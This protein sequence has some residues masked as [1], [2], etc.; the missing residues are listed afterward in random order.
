MNR[1][2]A[3][4]V[5]LL[6]IITWLITQLQ[7][8]PSSQNTTGQDSTAQS[9]SPNQNAGQP[10]SPQIPPALATALSQGAHPTWKPS[11]PVTGAPLRFGR[12]QPLGLK[13]RILPVRSLSPSTGYLTESTVAFPVHDGS[14]VIG[15][16]HNITPLPSG[17]LIEGSLPENGSFSVTLRTD[18]AS[19]HLLFPKAFRAIEVRTEPNGSILMI[20]R[21]LS[22][23]LCAPGLPST[24]RHAA[25]APDPSDPQRIP[26]EATAPLSVPLLE[27]L[28][29]VAA[30]PTTRAVI[31]P[32][33]YLH[34]VNSKST[35]V[36]D[37]GYWN[38]GRPFPVANTTLSANDIRYI[39]D[40]VAEDFRPFKVNVTTNPAIR[41]LAIANKKNWV[42]VW[43][44][45]TKTAE[46]TAGGIAVIDGFSTPDRS[47]SS[48]DPTKIG[49][50]HCWAFTQTKENCADTISHEA[51]HTFGLGHWG[52]PS[53]EYYDGH[54]TSSLSWKPIMGAGDKLVSH[55]TKAGSY[56]QQ[57]GKKSSSQDDTAIIQ[58]TNNS[59]P[60]IP[61]EDNNS[62]SSARPLGSASPIITAK[63]VIT[64]KADVDFFSFT[65]TGGTVDVRCSPAPISPNL[66][67]RLSLL[68][69]K[70]ELLESS[71]PID[72]M[73]AAINCPVPRGTYYVKVEGASHLLPD[74]IPANFFN[75]TAGIALRNNGFTKHGSLGAYS[76]SGTISGKANT[77][78]ITSPP[79]LSGTVYAAFS[80]TITAI[81]T[82]PL[83]EISG[84]LPAGLSFDP[85]TAT[86]SGVPTDPNTQTAAVL[87]VP[88]QR[89]FTIKGLKLSK[90]TQV[91]GD[92]IPQ[93]T[94]IESISGSTITL[95]KPCTDYSLKT[96]TVEG[97]T[98]TGSDVVEL[99]SALSLQPTINAPIQGVGI[100]ADTVVA[101]A[102]SRTIR[103]SKKATSSS[104]AETAFDAY[105]ITDSADVTLSALSPTPIIGSLMTGMGIPAGAKIIDVSDNIVTLSKKATL[106]PSQHV[107][108]TATTTRNSRSLRVRSAN[109]YLA[110]GSSITGPGIPANT[111]VQ[112]MDG[113]NI[114]LSKAATVTS[115][116]NGATG[117]KSAALITTKVS[118]LTAKPVRITTYAHTATNLTF[119]RDTTLKVTARD[120]YGQSSSQD[121]SIDIQ[122]GKTFYSFLATSAQRAGKGFAMGYSGE[123]AEPWSSQSTDLPPNAN[124][125]ETG[126]S[127]RLSDDAYTEVSVDFDATLP[128][129]LSFFWKISSEPNYDKLDVLLNDS[130]VASLSGEQSWERTTIVYPSGS[131]TISFRYSKDAHVTMGDDRAFIGGL[132]FGETP[133]ITKHP[134]SA[135]YSS[136][137]TPAPL[138]VSVAPATT[139]KDR[140]VTYQWSARGTGLADGKSWVS[141]TGAT[142][143][144]LTPQKIGQ[145]IRQYRCT[146]SNY[147]GTTTSGTATITIR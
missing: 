52:T 16:I 79:H 39:H 99:A 128:G 80:Q 7:T 55:W 107:A 60:L 86:I 8:P 83:I 92:G 137:Q 41:D 65:S 69:A 36:Y 101:S 110:P 3:G 104:R 121:L 54:G 45:P 47:S 115:Q 44:T 1:R 123:V 30:T 103:L 22:D 108:F 2:S 89:T 59:T 118:T 120:S 33:I 70:G 124:L 23:V 102:T 81:G 37:K 5:S 145:S 84:T 68:N 82:E 143:P 17:T 51:G 72:R 9:P 131:H 75:S 53:E 114:T 27:S 43:I 21:L 15:T 78:A 49:S 31:H 14:V 125:K 26:K 56:F 63:G 142:S 11:G 34:F 76:L 85:N 113:E 130:I 71:S 64:D 4:I 73:D 109:I 94:V 13:G 117:F 58:R 74:P 96:L 50:R 122:P 10:S 48:T 98:T 141:L 135:S 116:P 20:E 57:V 105:V 29:N 6:G 138:S 111:F 77:L 61:D 42:Q 126:V 88:N 127:G 24:P 95:S 46:P 32:V 100:P 35:T 87:R 133:T 19:G 67:V 90:G 66:K 106:T 28:P 134:L 97:E 93:D 112:S 25:A 18:A 132:E 40:R 144:S 139:S 91:S 38:K 129:G 136:T 140:N 146:I 12:E 119:R 62:P 147:F